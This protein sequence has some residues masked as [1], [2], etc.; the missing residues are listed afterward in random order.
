MSN[1]DYITLYS[2]FAM[3]CSFQHNL[4]KAAC[5]SAYSLFLLI[6]YIVQ[7]NVDDR[8]TVPAVAPVVP[9]WLSLASH[10]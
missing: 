10:R 7:F 3:L 9:V 2:T 1:K 5:F 8:M 6:I 4:A